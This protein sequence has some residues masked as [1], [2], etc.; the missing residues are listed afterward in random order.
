MPDY[1]LFGNIL[2]SDLAFPELHAC[3]AT[4]PPKWVLTRVDSAP[5]QANAEA[6]GTETVDPGINVVL[7]SFAGRLRLSFDDTGVFDVSADGHRIEWASPTEPDLAAA[8]KDV[9]GRVMAVCL[10]QEGI[11][12]LHGSAVA[13]N[14][15]AL[16]FLAPKFHGKS[17][18]ATA[19]VESGAR[20]LADD[21]VAVS[22]G[23]RPVVMPSV[24][25]VQ[26]WKDSAERA[27]GTSATVR[28]DTDA[29]K[30]QMAWDEPERSQSVA[31]PLAAVYLLA[32]IS[33]DT[34]GAAVRRIRLPGA[35]AT[36]ALLG[37]GKIVGLLGGRHRVSLLRRIADLA[38]HVPVYRLEIPRDFGR[39]A[40]LTSSLWAWHPSTQLDELVE[41]TR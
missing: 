17:T 31:A 16:A 34:E 23:P 4:E 8:R 6:V 38:E 25:V 20:L 39:I 9:L 40:E 37:Q 36:V 12:T 13:L 24:P 22:G 3:D 32:P 18:T 11:T 28:G 14:G 27:T 2:R 1:R 26:L 30:V 7:S 33:P 29:P 15:M 10:E 41:R 5:V 35:L 19:L 21:L